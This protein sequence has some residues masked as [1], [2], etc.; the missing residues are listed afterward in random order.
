MTTVNN[1][2]NRRAQLSPERQALL[3]KLK[4]GALATAAPTIPRRTADGPIPLSFAQQRLWF[5]DQLAPGSANY[6]MPMLL[7]LTGKLDV[8]ALERSINEVVRRNEILRTTFVTVD[9][10]PQQVIQSAA[11]HPEGTRL[12]IVDLQLLPEAERTEQ[13]TQ[14]ALA[15][16]Q[17][18]FDLT[19]DCPFRALL[20]RLAE[21]EHMLVLI[22]HHIVLDGSQALLM[23]ELQTLYNAYVA[24]TTP[25]LPA[26]PIQYADFADWQRKWLQSDRV[27]VELDYWKQQLAP[28]GSGDL[29][30]LDLPIARPRPPA[31]TFNGAKQKFKFSQAFADKVKAL[32][33]QEDATLFMTLLAGFQCVL[34]RYTGQSK[35]TVGTPVAQ[36]S[37]PEIE[38]MLGCFINTVVMRTDLAGNPSFREVLQRV[39][40]VTLGAFNHQQVPI[41]MVVES[42][43]L[44]RDASRN[45]LYQVM[46]VLQ[47]LSGNMLEFSGLEARPFNVDTATARLDL[48]LY[49]ET[50][51]DG[52]VGFLEYNTDLF[53]SASIVRLLR[54]FETLMLAA[55]DNPERRL[56]DLPLL[57]EADREQTLAAWNDTRADYERMACMHQLFERQAERTPDATAVIFDTAQLSYRELNE[58][59]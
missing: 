10:Q 49:L 19:R 35:I 44:E 47:Q 18:P 20:I 51:A 29:A 58:E 5:L 17:Q 41:E 56:W 8:A 40:Q 39:R 14:T 48:L 25:Q 36:R 46:F 43:Q 1:R 53:E 31:Q 16:A 30:P 45:P 24:G 13:M 34:S 27:Q 28:N 2:S 42:L 9:G 22:S 11:A 26:L 15:A 32:S 57:P 23:Q 12:L 50:S 3:A 52:L 38:R 55:V 7:I 33:E 6:N 54:H 37:Q 21:A 4:R 59:A